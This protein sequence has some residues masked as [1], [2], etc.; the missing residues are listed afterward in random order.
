MAHY[1]IEF[2]LR[3]F[4]KKY[5]QELIKEIGRKFRVRGMKDKV[6]HITL[7]GP[8]TTNNERRMVSEVLNFCRKYK[9]VYFSIKGFDYFNN[10]AN[11]V[12]YLNIAPSEELK[13]FRFELASKL[14]GITSTSSKEDLK[15]KEDFKF[16]STI[17]F[18]DIDYKLGQILNH[19]KNKQHPNIRQTLLRL[20]ILRNGKILNEYDF[21]QNRLF[22]RRQSLNKQLWMRTISILKQKPYPQQIKTQ[23]IQPKKKSILDKIKSFFAKYG[24]S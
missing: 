20:T 23:N 19:L 21:L 1:L 13:I 9:R 11:K 16:H 10:P 5:S 2:R 24:Y 6:S 17:A 18:K 7:Y 14:R 4:A 15:N 22:N 12:V 3:G 8:F